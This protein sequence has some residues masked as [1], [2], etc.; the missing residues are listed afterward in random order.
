MLKRDKKWLKQDLS[1]SYKVFGLYQIVQIAPNQMNKPGPFVEFYTGPAY[2]SGLAQSVNS[3]NF[4]IIFYREV[5]S[6]MTEKIKSNHE[7]FWTIFIF[8]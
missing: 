2:L 7:V 6:Q 3:I 4:V 8:F 5:L 1:I